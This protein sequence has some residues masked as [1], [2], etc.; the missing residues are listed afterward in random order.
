VGCDER[1]TGD[2]VWVGR[3]I[4]YALVRQQTQRSE[5]GMGNERG[6]RGRERLEERGERAGNVRNGAEGWKG[7]GERLREA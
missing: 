6:Y 7:L 4:M 1:D 2:V 5:R 3:M